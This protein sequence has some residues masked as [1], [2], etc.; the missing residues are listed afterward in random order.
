MEAGELGVPAGRAR[1]H[2]SSQSWGALGSARGHSSIRTKP[3]TPQREGHSGERGEVIPSSGRGSALAPASA[4]EVGTDREWLGSRRQLA[5]AGAGCVGAGREA[6]SQPRPHRASAAASAEGTTRWP[7]RLG[8]GRA[9]SHPG[10]AGPRVASWGS[11]RRP[12]PRRPRP[13]AHSGAPAAAWLSPEA[14]GP[15][16]RAGRG[17][18]RV[19]PRL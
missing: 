14:A 10:P 5:L 6:L 12:A 13:P 1:S 2:S 16:Q 17:C 11:Y 4:R 8:S 3:Q 18:G 9:P 19:G 7:A 15:W